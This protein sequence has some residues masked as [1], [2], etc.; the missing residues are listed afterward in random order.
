M[1]AL[2]VRRA[3][4]WAPWV[5]IVVVATVAL[6]VGSERPPAPGTLEQRTLAIAS[7][8]RC[9][10]CVGETAAGSDTAPSVAIRDEIR[11]GLVAGEKPTTILAGIVAAYGPGILEKP[12][13][14]GVDL[15]V[16]VI[17]VVVSIG[18]LSGLVL[19][20]VWWQ[21]RRR[22]GPVAS[23]EDRRLVAQLLGSVDRP[24]DGW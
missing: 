7:E 10:V 22:A 21:R 5:V 2:G 4:R 19:G 3:L 20:F 13:T 15:L 24:G 1:M 14:S 16:W 11:Q 12:R 8:V 17:P 6:A 9:P 23:E 18:A